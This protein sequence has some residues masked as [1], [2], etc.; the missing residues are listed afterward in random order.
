LKNISACILFLIFLL[1]TLSIRGLLEVGDRITFKSSAS[2]G[3]ILILPEGGSSED[4]R[5]TKPFLDYATTHAMSW[6]Q[7]VNNVLGENAPNGSLY[8]VTGCDKTRTWG[9][10][11]FSCLEPDDLFIEFVRTNSNSDQGT[12]TFR[13]HYPAEVNCTPEELQNSPNWSGCVFVR[14]F[15]VA[16]RPQY[17]L[18]MFGQ[19]VDTKS[20]ADLCDDDLIPVNSKHGSPKSSLVPK[21]GLKKKFLSRLSKSASKAKKTFQSGVEQEKVDAQRFPRPAQVNEM[22]LYLNVLL[23]VNS[24]PSPYGSDQQIHIPKSEFLPSLQNSTQA[25]YS[26][27]E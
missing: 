3:A 5:N 1:L 14:G 27:K 9:A 7:H 11:A 6:Y 15:M 2:N 20:I 8:V 4:L 13:N 16:M 21:I 23:I 10:C 19:T 26:L 17:L 24:D 25:V 18:S 22:E 12:Y